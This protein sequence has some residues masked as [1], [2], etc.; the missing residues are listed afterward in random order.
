MD[1]RKYIKT[2]GLA[3]V[4]T[5]VLAEACNPKEKTAEAASSPAVEPG[6]LPY[7][8]E[9][10]KKLNAER[11]FT[12]HEMATITFLADIIIPRDE[13]SG[14]ASE[15]KVPEFIEFIVKDMPAHQVP[16][17]GGLKWLDLQC[18]NRYKAPFIE[19]SS[20]QQ[21]EMVSDIAYPEKVKPGMEPGVSF[22]TRMR[23]LTASGFFTTEMGIK[24]LGYVGNTPNKW[25]GVPIDILKQYGMENV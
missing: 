8:L 22:F 15:A 17:Q 16:M 13:K 7:E 12:A 18:Y 5:G 23:D 1:R 6:R 20:E 3:V 9:H 11:F 10:N 25:E 24:D 2:L 4:S 14:S 21:I 19:C